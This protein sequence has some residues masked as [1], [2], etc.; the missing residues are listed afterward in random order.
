MRGTSVAD[1]LAG[2]TESPRAAVRTAGIH[3]KA[4]SVR[5]LPRRSA[6]DLS[7]SV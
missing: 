6:A 3:E 2:R 4:C 5:V 7:R 1:T